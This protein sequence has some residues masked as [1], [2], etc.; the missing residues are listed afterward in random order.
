MVCLSGGKDSYVLLDLLRDL[1]ARAP[2]AFDLLAVT[3]DQVQPGFQ[4]QVLENYLSGEQ[5]SAPY[6][7]AGHLR[8]RGRQD[9]QR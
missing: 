6:R 2:V 4:V 3:L 8:D 5:I 9:P 1:Q 7:A